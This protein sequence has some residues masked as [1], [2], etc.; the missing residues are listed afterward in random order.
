M[1]AIITGLFETPRDAAVAIEMLHQRGIPRA[2]I[3]LVAADHVDRDA[4]AID[5]HSKLPEGAAIGAGVGGAVGAMVAGL[6][7]IGVIATGGVGLVAAGPVLA[8]F[9]GAGA[10][11]AAGSAVGALVGYAIPEHEVKFYENAIREGSVLVGAKYDSAEQKE[12]IKETFESIDATHV[13][14]A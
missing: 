2:N 5:S 4:F 12:R 8:A 11:A 13:S 10:G 14:H 1:S 9:A 6:T 7:A 3:S